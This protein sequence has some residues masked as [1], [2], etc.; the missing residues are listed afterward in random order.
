MHKNATVSGYYIV[1]R[2]SGPVVSFVDRDDWDIIMACEGKPSSSGWQPLRIKVTRPADDNFLYFGN[3]IACDGRAYELL[4]QH[5][6]DQ[7][8][9]L[10]LVDPMSTKTYYYMNVI[11]KVYDSLDPSSSQVIFN[12]ADMRVLGVMH[13][14]F[15][16]SVLLENYLFRMGEYPVDIFATERFKELVSDNGLIGLEFRT[17]P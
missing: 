6:G 8:E 4:G 17:P 14:H 7:V 15:R 3:D 11:N 1:T 10:P 13:H 2:S 12:P 16:E 5:L 9:W